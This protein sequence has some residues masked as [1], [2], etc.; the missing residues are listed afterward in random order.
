MQKYG[1]KQNFSHGSFPE[2][3]EKQKAEKKK[4]KKV[5]KNNGQLRFRPP[6][7]AAHASRLDQKQCREEKEMYVLQLANATT[8]GAHKP[9]GPIWG[10]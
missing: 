1:G 8:D 2:V 9:P 5:G 4:K 10:W 6:P 7:R 3:G